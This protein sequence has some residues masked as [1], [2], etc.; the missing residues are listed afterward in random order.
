MAVPLIVGQTMKSML[1]PQV[2]QQL[3]NISKAQ[4]KDAAN[5]AISS[6]AG[7]AATRAAQMHVYPI[8]TR[9]SKP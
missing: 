3:V 2:V 1:T 8:L 6:F 4:G 7:R 9:P 5:K